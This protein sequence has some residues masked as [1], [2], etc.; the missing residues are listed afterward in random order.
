MM[1]ESIS[2]CGFNLEW[3]WLKFDFLRNFQLQTS[4][5]NSQDWPGKEWKEIMG[6]G[7]F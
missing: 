1:S 4:L 7:D 5:W 3:T 6:K 2:Q